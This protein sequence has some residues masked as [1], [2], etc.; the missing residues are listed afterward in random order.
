MVITGSKA[1]WGSEGGGGLYAMGY[2][3]SAIPHPKRT[4]NA[5]SGC[6]PP[7]ARS[8][9]LDVPV[10][11]PIPP[12]K[13]QLAR[14]VAEALD[15]WPQAEAAEIIGTDQPRLS[16]LRKGRLARFSLEQLI[17]FGSRAG[18][19]VSLSLTWTARRRFLRVRV[20]R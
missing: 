13:E 10:P 11:D 3:N 8:P 6:R 18:A 14:A 17:R 12:L 4:P 2:G 15:G 5:K 1:A 16:D 20:P 9:S 19:D 7:G